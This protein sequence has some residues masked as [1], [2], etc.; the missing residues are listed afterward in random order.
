VFP[1]FVFMGTWMLCER[2]LVSMIACVFYWMK[3]DVSKFLSTLCRYVDNDV[4]M[5]ILK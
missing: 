5:F 1:T 4:D 2:M 3:R